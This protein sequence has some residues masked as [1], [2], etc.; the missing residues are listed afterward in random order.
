MKFIILLI[1]QIVFSIKD[2]THQ[3]NKERDAYDLPFIIRNKT[4]EAQIYNYNHDVN[5]YYEQGSVYSTYNYANGKYLK[6][7][8]D[9]ITDYMNLT[10]YNF[11]FRDRTNRNIKYI[12]SFRR[13][14][15]KCFDFK[16]CNKTNFL[17]YTSCLINPASNKPY[18]KCSWAWQYYP[19]II[20]RSL[21]EIA[22]V[23]LGKPPPNNDPNFN[24]ENKKG[25]FFCYGKYNSTNDYPFD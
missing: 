13:R 19:K 8:G 14:Q 16:K 12:M 6:K 5:W 1:L 9:H 18:R 25:A 21:T 4:L 22:C 17:G 24:R 2:F 3:I 10:D 15:R 11:L 7:N 23:K 20:E